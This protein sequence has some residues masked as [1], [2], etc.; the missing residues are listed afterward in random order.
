MKQKLL[1]RQPFSKNISNLKLS[2][3][4]PNNEIT[5]RNPLTNKMIINYNMLAPVMMDRIGSEIGCRDIIRINLDRRGERDVK[6][7]K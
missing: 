1:R 5:L 7:V 6:I 4:M 3:N 2:R